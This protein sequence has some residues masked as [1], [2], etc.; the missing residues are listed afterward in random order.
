MRLN[1]FVLIALIF[2]QFGFGH[3]AIRRPVLKKKKAKTLTTAQVYKIGPFRGEQTIA[4]IP[5][6]I[7]TF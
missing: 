1:R 3:G 2:S 5:S 4:A 7:K 6:T